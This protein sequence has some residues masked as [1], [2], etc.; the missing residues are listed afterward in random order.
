MTRD[1][2]KIL[3]KGMKAVYAQQ[4]FLPDKD[5]FDMWFALLQDLPYKLAN[6]AIQKHMLTE[7]F[8]P[9]PAE[10]REKAAQMIEVPE[11]EMSELEAWALVRKAI[12]NSGYH[13][14][15][16]FDKLPEACREAVGN[17]ANLEEWAKMDYEKVESVGQSHFIRNFRTAVLRIKEE[18]R[19]PEQ[20]RKLI[21]EMRESRMK[22]EDKE[23]G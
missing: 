21:S 15:E 3:V 14:Q 10:I 17:A 19:L 16:E 18:Q 22:I 1:E 6:V 7:K 5:A 20:T 23:Q 9:T 13:A 8:P 12:R 2:F 4:T 11:T